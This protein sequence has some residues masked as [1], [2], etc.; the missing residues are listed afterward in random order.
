MTTRKGRAMSTTRKGWKP[1][2]AIGALVLAAPALAQD[3]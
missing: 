1:W 2:L 3:D